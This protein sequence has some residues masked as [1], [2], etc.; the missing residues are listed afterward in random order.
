[1]SIDQRI[2]NYLAQQKNRD[3]EAEFLELCEVFQRLGVTIRLERGHFR[4]G[5]CRLWG[6]ELVLLLNRQQRVAE[7]IDV[8]LGA[9]R[10]LNHETVYLSPRIREQLS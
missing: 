1:M 6:E 4:S 3:K 5:L 10:S 7:L 8:M 9:L 2:C